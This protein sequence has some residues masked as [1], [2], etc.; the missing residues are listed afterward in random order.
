MHKWDVEK[1]PNDIFVDLF[2]TPLPL[3]K[4]QF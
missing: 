1:R 2:D 4:M 3:K